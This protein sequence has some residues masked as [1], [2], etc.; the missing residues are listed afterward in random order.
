MTVS[1]V[2][3]FSRLDYYFFEFGG[4][5]KI[6]PCPGPGEYRCEL[7]LCNQFC[8][9]TICPWTCACCQKGE[10]GEAGEDAEDGCGNCCDML[11]DC[12]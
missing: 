7:T 12:V 8:C 11:S 6:N 10:E 4:G 5:L 9:G 1:F 3:S 2:L